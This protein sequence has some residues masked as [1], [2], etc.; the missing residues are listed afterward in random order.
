[1]RV[2]STPLSP[3]SRPSRFTVYAL[4]VLLFLGAVGVGTTCE[5]STLMDERATPQLL[6]VRVN[7]KHFDQAVRM[8]DSPAQGLLVPRAELSRWRLTLPLD[9]EAVQHDGNAYYPLR[10][11][12]ELEYSIDTASQTL[13]VQVSPRQLAGSR[14]DLGKA[15]VSKVHTGTPGGFINYDLLHQ[16]RSGFDDSSS[17]TFELAGFNSRGLFTTTL[18]ARDHNQRRHGAGVVRLNTTLRRDDP[19]NLQTLTLGDTY[20][21][22]GAWGRGVLYGGIQWGTNFGTRPDFTTFPLPGVSGEAVVPSQVEVFA[23]NRRQAVNQIDS[24]PFSVRN[25]P[26]TTGTNDLRLT[27]TDV[28]GREQVIDRSFYASQQLLRSD[29]HDYTF[30]IGAIREDYTVQSNQYGRGFAAATHRLG[31]TDRFTGGVRLEALEDQQTAGVSGVWLASPQLGIVTGSVA[32]STADVGDGGLASIGIEHRGRL[33]SLGANTTATTTN[34]RQLG[35]REDQSTPRWTTRA[36][37]GARLPG[38]GAVGLSYIEIDRRDEADSRIV[39][40]NYSISPSRD[41]SLGLFASQELV[42][43]DSFVGLTLSMSLGSRTNASVSHNRDDGSYSNRVQLQRNTPRGNGFGYRVSAED[44]HGDPSRGDAQ[45]TARTD[46]GTY[47]AEVARHDS[48]TAYRFNASGGVV[49]LGGSTF[50]TRRIDDSFGVVKVGDYA[51][52][53]VY[54]ENQPVA[55]T[56]RKGAALVPDLRSFEKNRLSFEQADLPLGARLDSR[57]ANIAPGFRRGVLVAFDV[58]SPDGAL[59]TVYRASGEPLPAGATIRHAGSD[60]RFPVARR[61][62][63]WVTGLKADNQFVARWGAHSCRFKASM[64]ANP[65]PMPR[66]G[67]LI[68]QEEP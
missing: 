9:I 6:S 2:C 43:H 39:T 67:P 5:A 49:M 53:T 40:A 55:T 51:G 22:S 11:F 1:M 31:F 25:I 46:F 57:D 61:G 3:H 45:V 44:G 58:G 4:L 30:E 15:E 24:G 17:G 34:F 32:G 42:S 66:I 65:G 35:L 7:G 8:F 27:I 26:V 41:S 19:G 60:Q 56:N 54:N 68:C 62:E 18:L 63:A 38:R 48:N 33:F 13:T 21:R 64:P 37:I 12:S 29:L 59:L 16:V 10:R 20:S 50:A 36:N 28:L 23:N 14:I 47:R 52:V